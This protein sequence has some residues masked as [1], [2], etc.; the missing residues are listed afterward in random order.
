[1]S[2]YNHIA[3]TNIFLLRLHKVHHIWALSKDFGASGFRIATLY[4]KNQRL[5]SSIANLNIFSGVSQPMQLVLQDVLKDDIFIYG[6]LE[7]SRQRIRYSYELCVARL[8]EMV[9]PYV[10]AQAGIFV[11]ADFS[12]LLP[13]QTFSGEARFSSLLLDAARII[14]TPGLAQHDRKPGM[15]RICYAFV[16]PEVLDMALVR[17]DRIVGK[18]RRWHWDNLNAAELTD[19]L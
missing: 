9:I 15:F 19:I 6:F 10:H 7:N 18:I 4:S 17:L 16:T 3:L 1:M 11:Y 14:M 2:R 13:E 8:D 5:L 12:S